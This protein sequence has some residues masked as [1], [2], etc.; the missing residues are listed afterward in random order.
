[1]SKFAIGE[2]V[3]KAAD[4]HEDGRTVIFVMRSTWRAMARSSFSRKKSWSF[5]PTSVLPFGSGLRHAT[6]GCVRASA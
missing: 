4:D 2:R 5:T 1:M 3:E 6:V